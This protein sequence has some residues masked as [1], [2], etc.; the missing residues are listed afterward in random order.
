VSNPANRMEK[1]L[2]L[3]RELNGGTGNDFSHIRDLIV[4]LLHYVDASNQGA[5]SYELL[6]IVGDIFTEEKVE[7]FHLENP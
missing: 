7:S 5:A 2:A 3:Y 6:E 1:V 4:D